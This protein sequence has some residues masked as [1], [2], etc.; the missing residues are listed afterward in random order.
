MPTIALP[1]HVFFLLVILLRLVIV[2]FLAVYPVCLALCGGGRGEAEPM[3][4]PPQ[5]RVR[6]TERDQP[7]RDPWP[8]ALVYGHRVMVIPQQLLDLHRYVAACGWEVITGAQEIQE[9][10]FA[11]HSQVEFGIRMWL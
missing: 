4:Q 3:C 11:Q 8:P 7:P 6:H 2:V 5:H 9:V 10:G 1:A